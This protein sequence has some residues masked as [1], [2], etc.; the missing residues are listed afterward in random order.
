[1]KQH[2]D[3]LRENMGVRMAPTL[4]TKRTSGLAPREGSLQG[5]CSLNGN[6]IIV[7]DCKNGNALR[8]VSTSWQ[9]EDLFAHAQVK[10]DPLGI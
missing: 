2:D 3:S 4:D 10:I 5:V 7:L 6:Y 8:K 9:L 1:M